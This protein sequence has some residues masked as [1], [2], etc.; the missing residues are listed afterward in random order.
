MKYTFQTDNEIE[1]KQLMAAKDAISIIY[2]IREYLIKSDMDCKYKDE[3]FE[4]INEIDLDI[5]WG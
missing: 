2:D 1:A 3:I 4:F 5:L